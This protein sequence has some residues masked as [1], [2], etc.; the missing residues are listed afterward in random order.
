MFSS[1]KEQTRRRRPGLRS[2]SLN[3]FFCRSILPL[4]AQFMCLHFC[5]VASVSF[6]DTH[7]LA[8]P[9][10]P[11]SSFTPSRRSARS[12]DSGKPE[13]DQWF[14]SPLFACTSCE[15][16]RRQAPSSSR[17]S[18]ASP[19][20]LQSLTLP[21]SSLSA[22]RPA[23][24]RAVGI[25][26]SFASAWFLSESLCSTNRV[27]SARSPHSSLPFPLACEAN[28]ESKSV[29][30]LRSKRDQGQGNRLVTYV[31][32][33]SRWASPLFLSAPHPTLGVNAF[34]RRSFPSTLS[35]SSCSA[36]SSSVSA[37]ASSPSSS[38]SPSP[39]AEGGWCMFPR[40]LLGDWTLRILWPSASSQQSRFPS[41]D[42]FASLAS[43]PCLRSLFPNKPGDDTLANEEEASL[44]ADPERGDPSRSGEN[45]LDGERRLERKAH[46]Q[47][48][49]CAASDARRAGDVEVLKNLRASLT[50]SS[51]LPSFQFPRQQR[52]TDAAGASPV[53]LSNFRWLTAV[54][55]SAILRASS[56]RF[57][58]RLLPAGRLALLGG[59]H[60]GSQDDVPA[61]R[62]RAGEGGEAARRVDE[63][64]AEQ[65]EGEERKL[66]GRKGE[67]P[68]TDSEDAA[69]RG[70]PTDITSVPRCL[71]MV[72]GKASGTVSS[73]LENADKD[74][75]LFF[76][77]TNENSREPEQD[78]TTAANPG[79]CLE[80]LYWR[81]TPATRRLVV[82][83]ALLPHLLVLRFSCGI[84]WGNA[85]SSAD[86]AR[87][88]RA[89]VST[90]RTIFAS[91]V[92]HGFAR[93]IDEEAK[94]R[95]EREEASS[96]R[97]APE[98]LDERESLLLAAALAGGVRGRGIV[99][100]R[101]L[102]CDEG[103]DGKKVERQDAPE[104]FQDAE[105][106][107][108][109][110]ATSP[111]SERGDTQVREQEGARFHRGMLT[112]E[113]LRACAPSKRAPPRW[114][115]ASIPL[116]EVYI[117]LK[118]PVSG[119]A[120]V[121]SRLS[122]LPR[123][124]VLRL[125]TGAERHAF[126]QEFRLLQ[127]VQKS[128]LERQVKQNSPEAAVRES[129][130]RL[131]DTNG[132][133]ERSERTQE[134]QKNESSGPG[135]TE[136]ISEVERD[137]EAWWQHKSG[138]RVQ[139]LGEKAGEIQESKGYEHGR[140]DTA[141]KACEAVH[142]Q[143]LPEEAVGGL[144]RTGTEENIGNAV[145]S[146]TSERELQRLFEERAQS[147]GSLLRSRG[148]K[149]RT[150]RPAPRECVIPVVAL[151]INA[152]II[153][154]T[155]PL[156]SLASA[157]C[158]SLHITEKGK[159]RENPEGTRCVED[160]EAKKAIAAAQLHWRVCRRLSRPDYKVEHVVYVPSSRLVN[161]VVKRDNEEH[162]SS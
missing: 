33:P 32:L 123:R 6:V 150:R 108:A 26:S 88:C 18:S 69:P 25:S 59:G 132:E 28:Q 98:S 141:A 15:F 129:A 53:S 3:A 76:A 23:A 139:A 154:W 136:R 45:W 104:R 40:W 158:G 47:G 109:V 43:P 134:G 99:S 41:W 44:C 137:R 82:E 113:M 68:E 143:E 4:S 79:L 85:L 14:F 11:L 111:G 73:H 29:P 30:K 142:H 86:I 57:R 75:C 102:L 93:L 135:V 5:L 12:W 91:R 8:Y 116:G 38:S 118:K 107:G 21:V 92:P 9:A 50:S 37:S 124:G 39:S 125:R 121:R 103:R 162:Q 127:Q 56:L 55:R 62:S 144:I 149:R 77:E 120:I 84:T 67:G 19:A 161:F 42:P 105:D 94:T 122:L 83:L 97:P 46:I 35:S 114:S 87:A 130:R 49:A 100:V 7:A 153:G 95:K 110:F 1:Q 36:A 117:Q 140:H 51:D 31:G 133:P 89:S 101:S 24:L 17:C 78:G 72:R 65:R 10:A 119:S 156:P 74:A 152:K 145:E 160:S 81:Y 27:F 48:G 58:I 96:E 63:R 61:E 64:E 16:P 20:F 52:A 138:R 157:S 159:R 131:G 128:F 146:T 148:K 147:F 54:Q 66:E 155:L 71:H 34:R 60:R 90:A 106:V 22:P 151:A 112:L 2:S 13:K 80:P 126:L 70:Q 115:V